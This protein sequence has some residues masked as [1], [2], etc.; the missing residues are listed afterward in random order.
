M[1]NSRLKGQRVLV[2]F[3]L[4]YAGLFYVGAS[5][6]TNDLRRERVGNQAGYSTEVVDVDVAADVQE[7]RTLPPKRR[8]C[9]EVTENGL[10]RRTRLPP[11]EGRL[12]R[13]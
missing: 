6:E 9:F 11:L 2:N 4:E 10:A 12:M 1:E 7:C 3:H 5:I 8:K 13:A